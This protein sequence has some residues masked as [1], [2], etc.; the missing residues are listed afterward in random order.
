MAPIRDLD[1]VLLKETISPPPQALNGI[2]FYSEVVLIEGN[3]V[4]IYVH[5]YA[6]TY[7]YKDVN[8]RNNL[9]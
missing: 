7:T 8:M 5:V 9:Q 6:Y 1:Y 2:G 4:Y 3:T